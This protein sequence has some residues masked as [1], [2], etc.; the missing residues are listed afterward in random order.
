M[1]L[2]LCQFHMVL[3]LEEMTRAERLEADEQAGRLACDLWR[4]GRAV[5]RGASAVRSGARFDAHRGGA[6]LRP[7]R[8]S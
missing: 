4:L 5:R 7:R 6:T 3:R 1:P 8:S 2:D